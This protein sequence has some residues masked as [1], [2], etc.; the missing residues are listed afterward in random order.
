MA[1]TDYL[2]SIA[3]AIREKTG[4]TDKLTALDFAELIKAIPQENSSGGGDFK[5]FDYGVE[6]TQRDVSLQ[7]ASAVYSKQFYTI[8]HNL[9]RT[10]FYVYI[11][12]NNKLEG[13]D[14]SKVYIPKASAFYF[15]HGIIK[16]HLNDIY[17]TKCQNGA[18]FTNANGSI[19]NATYDSS[20]DMPF[21]EADENNIYLHGL[22]GVSMFIVAGK[23]YQWFVA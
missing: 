17:V 19:T 12:Y 16:S 5:P 20:A 2:T 13:G 18:R 3:D 14:P 11:G 6:Y 4:R 15:A 9:G 10:P 23:P 21:I 22:T 7:R 8:P 1:L